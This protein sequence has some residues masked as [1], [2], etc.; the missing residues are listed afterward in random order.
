M[1]HGSISPSTLQKTKAISLHLA[2]LSQDIHT[3]WVEEA[4]QIAEKEKT[5]WKN[6]IS[7]SNE[8]Q[9]VITGQGHKWQNNLKLMSTHCILRKSKS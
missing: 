9:V 4:I 2:F 3:D 6:Q 5:T 1:F 8:E 7:T